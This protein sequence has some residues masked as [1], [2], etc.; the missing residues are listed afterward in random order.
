MLYKYKYFHFKMY[1]R[2]HLHR[3]Y[4]LFGSFCAVTG[5]VDN[6]CT[7]SFQVFISVQ[8]SELQYSGHESSNAGT[9][10]P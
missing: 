9:S 8:T 4:L 2:G 7:F 5:Q 3:F 10:Q 6:H 1:L